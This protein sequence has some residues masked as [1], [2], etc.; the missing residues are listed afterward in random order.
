M[1]QSWWCACSLLVAACG[2]P[3]PVPP[4]RMV[5]EEHRLLQPFHGHREIGCAELRIEATA[6]FAQRYIGI[7]SGDT[8]LQRGRKE[9]GDGYLDT[10]WS[11]V[12]GTVAGAF[13]LTIG[14]A[15]DVGG[16]KEGQFTRFT[17]V[18]EVRLRVWQDR[19]PLALDVVAK[20]PVVVIE[21][22]QQRDLLEYSVHDG[23]LHSR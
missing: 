19:R 2:A 5:G 16:L 23:V 17:V 14:E 18:R 13:L 10:V 22:G 1:R 21:S 12:S 6:N 11:N 15:N 7:P 3:P 4:E 8:A 20:G 9:Q